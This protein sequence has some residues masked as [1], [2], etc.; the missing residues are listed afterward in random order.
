LLEE[1]EEIL[2]A[3][4]K[5]STTPRY[6]PNFLIESARLRRNVQI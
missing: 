4:C 6:A 1:A 3:M 5:D 2:V